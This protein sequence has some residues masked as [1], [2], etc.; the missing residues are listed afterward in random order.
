[1]IAVVFSLVL[2]HLQKG[3]GEKKVNWAYYSTMKQQL[4]EIQMDA[5]F[6]LWVLLWLWFALSLYV[7]LFLYHT[8]QLFVKTLK[9]IWHS[10][11]V[12]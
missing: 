7:R 1:M 11:R 2:S 3:S 4:K 8:E 5:D 6:T 9:A 12:I 10:I